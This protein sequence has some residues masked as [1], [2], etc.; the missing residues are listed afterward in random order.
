M[1]DPTGHR[2]DPA[3]VNQSD[4]IASDD[5]VVRIDDPNQPIQPT[6]YTFRKYKIYREEGEGGQFGLVLSDHVTH[7]PDI[8]SKTPIRGSSDRSDRSDRTSVTCSH[9]SAPIP[10]HR[11]TVCSDACAVAAA[12]SR[13]KARRKRRRA[14]PRSRTEQTKRLTKRYLADLSE[15][16]ATEQRPRTWGECRERTGPCPWVGCPAHLYLDVTACG[17]VKINFPDL[18]PLEIEE[19][20]VLR[21]AECGEMTLEEVG[22]RMNLTRERVRQVEVRALIQLRRRPGMERPEVET[23]RPGAATPAKKAMP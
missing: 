4:R 1:N 16:Q 12:K 3:D 11:K 6:L 20:C 18:E 10:P 9:C 2:I 7:D 21:L 14:R 13:Q 17:S 19:P 5:S 22:A 15:P 23:D 8:D